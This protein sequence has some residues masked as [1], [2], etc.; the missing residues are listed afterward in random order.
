MPQSVSQKNFIRGLIATSSAMSQPKGS[1]PRGSNALLTRRGGI[2]TVDGSQ[3]L[4]AFNGAVQS[5]RGKVMASFLFSPLGV[6]NYYL[7]LM[8]ALDVPLGPPRN[9]SVATAG[10]GSL[11]A[12]TYY[13]E[14]TAL[15][16]AGGETT[17]SN[18]ANVV[19]GASG[20]NTLTWNIVPNAVSYNIY[21]S[22]APG[23]ETL[24]IG[25]PTAALPVPQPTYGT[26]TVSFID[27]GTTTQGASFTIVASPGGASYFQS[28]HY[29]SWT[30]TT[31]TPSGIQ[32]G[33]QF[34]VSGCTST[35]ATNPFNG[36]FTCAA[37]N[38][39]SVLA[40][41]SVPVS[42]PI[43]SITGGGGTLSLGAPPLSDT[44][45]QTALYKMPVIFGSPA[46]L[47]VPYNNSNIVALF[48]ADN[49]PIGTGGGGGS[50]GSG[51]GGGG[52]NSG[53]GTPSG[54]LQGNVSL[55]PQFVEFT[56]QAVMAL[57]NGFPPQVYSDSSGTSDHPAT[58]SNIASISVDAF[59]VV[60][61]TATGGHG[62]PTSANAG[63]N[64]LIAGVTPAGYNGVFPVLKVVSGTVLQ[65]RNLAAIGI[66]AGSGG[67]VTTTTIPL[68]S[69][70]VPAFPNWAAT[71]AYG[72]NYVVQPTIS[73][74]HYYK[75]IQSGTSGGSQPA[76]PTGTGQRVVDGS[77]IW[78]EAGL[79]NSAAPPPPGGAHIA[80]YSGA[81]WVLNTAPTNTATGIDGPCSLRM[82]DI[83]NL[84]SW[85]PIN[86]A[87]LDK[88]DGTEGMGLSSFTITAQG[89]PPQGSLVA[90]KNFATYQIL[91][92]FGAPD[93][94]IQRVKTDL[95]CTAPRTLQYVPGFGI[96]RFTHLGIAVFDGVDDR[97]VSEE[98][99][100]YLFPSNDG[101]LA[102]ITVVDANWIAIAWAAQTANPPMYAIAVPIGGSG[103]TLTRLFCYDLVLKAWAAPVDLP[104]P[105]GCISQF[106]TTSANP[107]TVMGGFSDG[108]LSRWQSGDILWDTG[109]TGAR[110]PSVVVGSV[111]TPT[112]ASNDPDQK[113]YVRRINIRGI[114]TNSTAG[115]TVTPILDGVQQ[116]AF[117]SPLLKSGTSDFE[118]E[119]GVGVTV[120]RAEAVISFS[121]DI[122]IWGWSW[123]VQP[124]PA[125]VP[126]LVT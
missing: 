29:K 85:N 38:G 56:N 48:P 41:Q 69:N 52:G 60:T 88:D 55:I 1:F 10:G 24:L 16:G 113:L 63:A 81:L 122:E 99:R 98:I 33:Q 91:G 83:N 74:G 15:D 42:L 93:F 22:T 121:G 111:K 110:S 7:A 102:D 58:V 45:Q 103:G 9:L 105:I 80:V 64:V 117:V 51:G 107:V 47:P 26:L 12:A 50:G 90:F 4:H 8:K 73:N 6:S 94:A 92:I 57:G 104:F 118:V 72:V 21:R 31:T 43:L 14:V 68:T 25:S 79:V 109:A 61:V 97:V 13:Y 39:N 35:G 78:Q 3:L 53:G 89:I 124:K 49:L 84:G 96:E 28:N 23:A 116:G 67:T 87:F 5:G 115:L 11:P 95:G 54:G 101:D 44:T 27:D 120:L 66:G 112:L 17:I 30:F 62:I 108:L 18:E 82:S 114:N 36:N 119:A 71:T 65:V 37:V 59:G 106:R 34:N 32:P 19:T 70:F 76:F 40:T 77:V 100:P 20:K 126:Q 75:C 125:G 86:Q 46:T 2:R 123:G